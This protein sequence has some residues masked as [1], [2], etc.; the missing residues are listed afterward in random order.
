VSTSENVSDY[1]TLIQMAYPEIEIRTARLHNHDGQF[2]I[3]AVINDALIFRF[4]RSEQVAE[5][6]KR[7]VAILAQLQGRLPLPIPNPVYFSDAPVFMGYPMLSG[8]PVRHDTFASANEAVVA[9]AAYT[10]ADFLKTLHSIP[11]PL[12]DLE[13][14]IDE[15]REDWAAMYAEIREKLY[16]FMRPDARQQVSANFER[17]LDDPA[18]WRFD[19]VLRHGDF[20]TRNILYNP[21]TMKINGVIDFGAA[22]ISDPAQDVGA[23]WSLGDR[24]MKPFFNA[25][26]EM[27]LTLDRVG[28]IRST[29]ALQQALYA[30]R[31]GNA[32]DFEDGIAQYR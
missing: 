4:P 25:Y 14:P 19:P 30:L 32:E 6:M 24:L 20:G 2:S 21:Q 9:S 22:G 28:F 27:R 5:T 17:A 11:L 23:V 16:P 10:L 8:E 1:C 29:Y 7:E 12:T 15:Q 13:L 26:P 3:V 31:D 18:L